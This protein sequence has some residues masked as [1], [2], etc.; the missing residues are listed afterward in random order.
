[1]ALASNVALGTPD[2]LLLSWNGFSDATSDYSTLTNED[3]SVK[4]LTVTTSGSSTINDNGLLTVVGASGGTAYVDLSSAGLTFA[5]GFTISCTVSNLRHL[6]TNSNGLIFTLAGENKTDLWGVGVQKNGQNATMMYE[7]SSAN[8]STTPEK[9]IKDIEGLSPQVVTVVFGL[10]KENPSKVSMSLYLN[11]ALAATGLTGTTDRT[12]ETIDKLYLGSW[13]VASRYSHVS[14]TIHS[15][16]IY[17][18]ALTKEEVQLYAPEPATAT[19]SLLA[20]A[21]LAGR[22]R[23]K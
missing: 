7:G 18:A 9:S 3:G 6:T 14:E 19:L 10:D 4:N 22:R 1:M 2:S 8:V 23:R 21:G 16:Q 5:G 15:L 17:N 11:G 12:G 20:L 13:G